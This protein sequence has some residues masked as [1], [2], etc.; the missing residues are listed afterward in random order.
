MGSMLRYTSGMAQ[1][2]PNDMP[3]Q[4]FDA[5]GA[6]ERPSAGPA[7]CRRHAC[8]F[9]SGEVRLRSEDFSRIPVEF[10]LL[11][12]ERDLIR[13]QGRGP[14]DHRDHRVRPY[15]PSPSR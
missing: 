2:G 15:K 13:L 9:S 5:T 1:A 11:T 4:W 10:C 12:D 14:S 3:M 6:T 8:V 7:A